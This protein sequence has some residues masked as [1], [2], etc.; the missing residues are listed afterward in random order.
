MIY[1]YI[2]VLR[3]RWLNEWHHLLLPSG[4]VIIT[5]AGWPHYWTHTIPLDNCTSVKKGDNNQITI[6][7]NVTR[8][9]QSSA[10]E[11]YEGAG[12]TR[13][14]RRWGRPVLYCTVLYCT[15]RP[16][17]TAPCPVQLRPSAGQ[18]E[19]DGSSMSQYSTVQYSNVPCHS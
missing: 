3:G 6:H 19:T 12:L 7:K 2:Y 9:P 17:L 8:W 5:M 10:P 18:H 1:T 14:G 4:W 15:A 16:A 11:H 13:L